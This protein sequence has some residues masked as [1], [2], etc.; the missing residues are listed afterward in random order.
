MGVRETIKH[1]FRKL[2]P[3]TGKPQQS[4]S[5]A[6]H[7]VPAQPH[8]LAQSTVPASS[9][10]LPQS[11]G[12]AQNTVPLRSQDSY[13][14]LHK[15]ELDCAIETL[16]NCNEAEA[17]AVLPILLRHTCYNYEEQRRLPSY[18]A[19]WGTD[20]ERMPAIMSGR[21]GQFAKAIRD[22]GNTEDFKKILE[23]CC[24]HLSKIPIDRSPRS[25][26][27]HLHNVG[28]IYHVALFVYHGLSNVSG[29]N[30][31]IAHNALKLMHKCYFSTQ[32]HDLINSND[33]AAYVKNTGTESGAPSEQRRAAPDSNRARVNRSSVSE[34]VTALPAYKLAN[35]ASD[36]QY[37]SVSTP[38]T[39]ANSASDKEAYTIL[40]KFQLRIDGKAEAQRDYGFSRFIRKL[41]YID[42]QEAKGL[43]PSHWGEDVEPNL[44]MA[45]WTQAVQIAIIE[46]EFK[47]RQ[48]LIDQLKRAILLLKRQQKW[49]GREKKLIDAYWIAMFL[50]FHGSDSTVV[51]AALIYVDEFHMQRYDQPKW[52]SEGKTERIK[53]SKGR[54][55]LAN[56][57][58]D[59]KYSSHWA[60]ESTR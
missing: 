24:E 10:D 4:S 59:D 15:P 60:T 56:R 29:T 33:F 43:P 13:A 34:S 49:P 22:Y 35:S 11:P 42:S 48:P 55:H 44:Y 30:K 25:V 17:I 7:T 36:K 19:K 52:S 23:G 45:L 8:N 57:H 31:E 9:H 20:L 47:S 26:L 54:E 3:G 16:K 18:E 12:A 58:R 46:Y 50:S 5:T 39:P 51:K 37:T 21:C 40:K 14:F 27:D 1:H 6:Q 53:D 32:S 2:K 38:H 41:Y 28:L